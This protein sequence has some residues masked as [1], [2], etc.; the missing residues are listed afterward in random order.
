MR[1]NSG[2]SWKR[3]NK[4]TALSAKKVTGVWQRSYGVLLSAYCL[5]LSAG[6][7]C[8]SFQR[9]FIRKPKTVE[10]PTAIV[11][12]QDYTHAMTPLDRYRKHYALFDYWNAQLLEELQAREPNAKRARDASA[13]A[14]QELRTLQGLLQ[15]ADAAGVARFIHER[16]PLDRELRRG[17]YAASGLSSMAQ[18]LER[19][20]RQIHRDL[21]WRDVQ[22]RLKEDATPHARAQ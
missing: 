7:G 6:M 5:V 21:Y 16:E 22:D 10:R 20:S 12:F 8:E 14:L 9:K 15:D 13:E 2:H 11:N 19:H 17:S 4:H 3:S 1:R 18:A